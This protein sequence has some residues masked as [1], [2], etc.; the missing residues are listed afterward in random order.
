MRVKAPC[1]DCPDRKVKCH[2]SCEKYKE[3][4]EYLDKIHQAMTAEDDVNDFLKTQ[5]ER[6]HKHPNRMKR[7]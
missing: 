1:K 4:R 7:K 2:S 5:G 6:R 3:Y